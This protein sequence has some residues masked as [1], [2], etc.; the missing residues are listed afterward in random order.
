MSFMDSYKRL[1]NLCRTFPDYPK[2]ISSYIEVMERCMQTR[3]QCFGWSSDYNRLKKY[4]YIRNQIAHANG[5]YEDD[6][7]TPEDEEWLQDFHTRIINCNDPVAQYFKSQRAATARPKQTAQTPPPKPTMCPQTPP[8]QPTKHPAG[9]AA[10]FVLVML[11]IVAMGWLV[12][13]L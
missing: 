8:S 12:F 6:L 9:C 11:I 2:G 10:C 7:C 1:D 13:H 3:H 5:V 4:R